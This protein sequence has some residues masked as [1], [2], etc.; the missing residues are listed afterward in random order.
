M[1]FVQREGKSEQNLLYLQLVIFHGVYK[2]IEN[3]VDNLHTPFLTQFH[4][5]RKGAMG[6]LKPQ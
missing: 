2:E 5:P 1:L 6:V 3:H 4:F